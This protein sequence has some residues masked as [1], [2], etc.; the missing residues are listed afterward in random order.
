MVRRLIVVGLFLNAALLTGRFW[1]EA[2]A[3]VDPVASENG[4]MNGDGK[5]D[6]SDPIFMLSWLFS[7]GPE[8][9]ACAQAGSDLEDR[10]ATLEA[11]VAGCLNLP[12]ANQNGVPD[13]S[14]GPF[15]GNG[16]CDGAETA[17]DCDDCRVDADQDGVNTPEDCDDDDSGVFPGAP[18]ACDLKDNDC[19]GTVDEGFQFATDPDH[20]GTCGN[21][22]PVGTACVAGQC[23]PVDADQDGF[24]VGPDCN[25]GDASIHPGAQEICDLKDNDCNGLFDDMV[26][27]PSPCHVCFNG[28]LISS[29]VGFPC[30]GG[31]CDGQGNCIGQ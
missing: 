23:A 31:T 14:E 17:E 18:E 22:C 8:P 19:D 20:C 12:D 2:A 24:V 10:V 21:K 25:D 16:Q 30:P 7:G 3:G 1:Q 15:C 9:V 29:P 11:V 26:A 27:V 28:Q 5:R 6:I 4:D 13:C